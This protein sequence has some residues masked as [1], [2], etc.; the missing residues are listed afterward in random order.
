MEKYHTNYYIGKIYFSST[1]TELWIRIISDTCFQVLWDTGGTISPCHWTPRDC[2]NRR[3]ET[4]RVIYGSF[5]CFFTETILTSLNSCEDFLESFFFSVSL[6]SYT[7]IFFIDVQA[8][9]ISPFFVMKVR[10]YKYCPLLKCCF[11]QLTHCRCI[12]NYT[13]YLVLL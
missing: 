10:L 13:F 7:W 6:F 12:L 5:S 2:W 3:A 4:V 9:M 11:S 8:I 1:F